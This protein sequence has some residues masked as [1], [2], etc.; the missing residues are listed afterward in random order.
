M[1]LE[2][3]LLAATFHM[4]VLFIVERMLT[5]QNKGGTTE[6]CLSSFAAKGF[7]ASYKLIMNMC[8]N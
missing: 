6:A 2:V 7:F 1:C 4:T 8:M 3:R 5:S